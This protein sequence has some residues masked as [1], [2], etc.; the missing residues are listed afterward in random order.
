MQTTSHT[1]EIITAVPVFHIPWT[2]CS[3]FVAEWT[4]SKW[5]TQNTPSWPQLLYSVVSNWLGFIAKKNSFTNHSIPLHRPTTPSRTKESGENPRE[6]HRNVKSVCRESSSTN[7]IPLCQ[8]IGHPYRAAY[9]W[10]YQLGDVCLS[11]ISQQ[12][13]TTIFGRDLGHSKLSPFV[14][15]S[16]NLFTSFLVIVVFVRATSSYCF[17]R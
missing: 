16:R 10:Q 6:I 12:K 4:C 17:I 7:Q 15:T 5:T 11:Q 9:T 2:R 1:R 3:A 13:A 8:T 14:L